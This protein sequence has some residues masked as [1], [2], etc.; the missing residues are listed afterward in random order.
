MT[1]EA[2]PTETG[3]RLETRGGSLLMDRHSSIAG[4]G[5]HCHSLVCDGSD[6]YAVFRLMAE[7]V[8]FAGDGTLYM[9]MVGVEPRM[10]DRY[11]RMG[12]TK[13]Y[14]VYARRSKCQE[15]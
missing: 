2:V 15:R 5:W 11:M 9:T 6:P 12:F 7:A 3:V 14:T 8:K 1:I 10:A 4:D 13:A